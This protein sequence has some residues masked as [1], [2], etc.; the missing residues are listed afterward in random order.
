VKELEQAAG[1]AGKIVVVNNQTIMKEIADADAVIG[2]ISPEQV[3]AG[4]NLKWVQIR[5]AGAENVLHRSGSNDLR[6]SQIILTNNQIV[7][8]P[9]IADHAMA[10]LLAHTRR[11]LHYQDLKSKSTWQGGNFTGIELNTKN[12]VVIGCGGIGKQI[13]KRAWAFGMNVDC[14]D[15]ED[16]YSPFLRKAVKPDQLNEVI[17]DAD[18]VF[19]SAHILP[20]AQDVRPKPIELMKKKQLL[21]R[22]KRGGLLRS[23]C[24]GQSARLQKLAGAGVD[25]G[26]P[27][28]PALNVEPLPA[29]HRCGIRQCDHH[30][31]HCQPFDSIPPHG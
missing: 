26:M 4:K 2:N 1:S 10:M 18:I 23:E 7:Q 12:A 13:S 30:S 20:K 3:R 6:D 9:E 8:G 16:I 29:G 27:S 31:P 22:R 19:I 11:L 28:T 15:P 25:V 5:S 24:A 14:V 17:P 21:H